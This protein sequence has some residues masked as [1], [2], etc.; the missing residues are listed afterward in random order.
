MFVVFDFIKRSNTAHFDLQRSVQR[1][2]R[3]FAGIGVRR[4]HENM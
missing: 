1:L 3:R 4:Q 2:L